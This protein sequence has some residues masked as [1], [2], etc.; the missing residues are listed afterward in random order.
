[1]SKN[2]LLGCIFI[3]IGGFFNVANQQNLLGTVSD[4]GPGYYPDLISE[5]LIISGLV[6]V[7]QALYK[8]VR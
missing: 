5:V 1:M 4:I 3:S 8:N 7:L 2:F 6:L